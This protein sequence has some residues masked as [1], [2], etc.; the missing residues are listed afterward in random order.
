MRKTATLLFL[1]ISA[2][3]IVFG[4]SR[5]SGSVKGRLLDS[6][7][8]QNLKDATVSVL[9]LKDSSL[10]VYALS[11]GDGSF[12]VDNVPFGKHVLQITFQGYKEIEKAFT[13]SKERTEF[14]AG[15]YHLAPLP[16]ELAG[17]TVKTAP[18]VIKGDTTEFNAGL[19]KTKPNAT[20]ED[21]LKK[22]PGVEVDKDGTVKAQ[23]ENVK[24]VLVDGKRFFGDDPKMA[25]RNLPTDM[26]D[27]VQ[28]YDAQ[29]DQSSFS[30]FDDGNREKTINII[31]KKDRRK[32]YF[33]KASVGFGND[34]RYGAN[35]NFNRFN[36][37]QQISFIGQGNNTNNQNFSIQDILGTMSSGGGGRGGGGGMFGGG[38][39][40]MQMARGGGMGNIGNFLGGTSPGV[41]TTWA[42]GLNYNDVWSKKTSVS[43]S[44]F[45]NNMDVRNSQD[46]FTENFNPNDSSIFRNSTSFSDNKNQNHRVNF[47]IDQKL[48]SM[49]SFLIRPSFSLQQSDNY[50]ESN[51]T[52]TRGKL[53]NQNETRSINSS[54]NDGY[55][56]NNSI[57]YRHRF[58]KKGRTLSV[59]FTQAFNNSETDRNT[60]NYTTTYFGANTRKDTINQVSNI[61]RDGRT[62]GGNLSYTEPIDAKSQLEMSYNVNFNLNNS[63]QQTLRYNKA[64]AKY[65][66]MDSLLSNTFENSNNSHRVGVS[67]RRQVNKDWSYTAGVG[68]QNAKLTSDNI[69]KKTSL[70]QS[71]NNFFPTLMVQYSKNR[72]KN[73][74][75]N[76]RGS[77]RQPAISQLQEVVDN[78]N[79]LN[80][81]TGNA[82]LQQEFQH[83][84]S[85]FYTKFDIF[86]F[87][88]FVASINGSLTNNKIGNSYFINTGNLPMQISNDVI[89]APLAQFTKPVNLDGA[90]NVNAF[91]NYGF[92]TKKP[93]ANLN[94]TT[95][96]LHS[97][98]VNLINNVKS[99]TKNY[100]FGETLRYTLN[101]KERL[102]L[103]FSSTS[104]YTMAR[105]SQSQVADNQ[106][107]PDGDFFTQMFTVEPT[108]S[109]KSGWVISSD[110]DYT[111]NRGQSEG[112]NQTIPLLG[113]S[114][115][116]MFLKSKKAEVKLSV[117]DLL[118]QNKSITR[119]VSQNYIEDVRTQVLNRYFM[120]TFT[121]NL[122]SFKG[123]QQQMPFPMNM[124]PRGANRQ[125]RIMQ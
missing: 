50:S 42:A 35:L 114:I 118:N 109:T 78:T 44:Y 86:T 18:V 6:I 104:T 112:Y 2:N 75:F 12:Q 29:S 93:K 10:I 33:G 81:S 71:F 37:N 9:D 82:G 30:G 77:T 120:L 68:V 85:L 55:N 110:F 34:S 45:Y 22:L 67:Y 38:G 57:L 26:I 21:L 115:G 73:L 105:Y 107:Q 60:L 46:K 14:D 72:T 121:Y 83:S 89:L 53:I 87:K 91:V 1:F 70:S 4:Q 43:G 97:R 69:S 123:Q 74:R 98:D 19:F 95:N 11:K 66:K 80:I 92:P 119:N 76:Y 116:K 84:F 61:T 48:D 64:T 8:N 79:P 23:G 16:A 7:S 27:K 106:Q 5:N 102:D 51:T 124:I 52:S 100:V 113:A 36:G 3:V 90:Y 41:A 59:N 125:M 28:V 40:M 65:D 31:T 103:N 111:I 101:Y 17:V 56:F 94:F 96:L 99:F 49:N 39:S 47:E 62:L 54:V 108:Y 117:F 63:S 58:D 15:I 25:T 32:G 20:A 24:R 88:N 13:V 122:R